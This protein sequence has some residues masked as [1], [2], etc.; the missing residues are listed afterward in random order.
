[1]SIVV[2]KGNKRYLPLLLSGDVYACEG[3]GW[4]QKGMLKLKVWMSITVGNINEIYLPQ[5]TEYEACKC[6]G[7]VW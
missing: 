1:M 3:P 5:V 6:E 4:E 2:G 7:P